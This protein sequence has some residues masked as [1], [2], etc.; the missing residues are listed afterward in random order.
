MNTI[1]TTFKV[2]SF[3]ES[4]GAL[5]GAVIDGCPAGLVL[6]LEA[7]QAA[8]NKRRTAQQEFASSRK[9]PDQV[10]IVSGVFEGKTLGS[11]ICVQINNVNARSSDYD[12]LR[13]MYRPGHADLTYQKK[14]GFRDHRGGGRSSI[15]IT[16]PM[17]AV[18]EIARQLICQSWPN[19]SCHSFVHQI[20]P[21][22]DP[23]FEIGQKPLSEA[24]LLHRANS[25]WRSIS[26][27][28]DIEANQ[29]I[30]QVVKDLDTC[31]GGIATYLEA[32]PLGIGEPIF[33]KLQA[34]LAHALFSIN[35][36]KSVSF[37]RGDRAASMKGSEHNDAFYLDES[38]QVR[39]KTNHH[40]GI[41]G[42]I[43]TGERIYLQSYF[44]PIS[45]IQQK[46]ETVDQDG[47]QQEI[48]IGGRHDVCAVPRAV[49]IVEA[50][51]QIVMADLLLRN[52]HS[53]I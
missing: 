14:Y 44:K 18:G 23:Q 40:G 36:V 50:Y 17:V 16:A 30:D 47:K 5:V 4:H 25:P 12:A 21:V 26:A 9:E 41:L 32:V 43:S 27:E 39:T 34:E 51:V 29:Y 13:K 42:G 7:I 52:K 38:N 46:Q 37:G 48:Q 49:P 15:R 24:E 10:E 45:S 53:S 28:F 1:G 11:P 2:S 20:G 35:T 8:V 19:F 6:D 22:L 31:G 33:G 3:G